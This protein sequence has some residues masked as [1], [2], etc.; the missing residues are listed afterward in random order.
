MGTIKVLEN[1]LHLINVEKRDLY[2]QD[3]QK[4]E[5]LEGKIVK[6]LEIENIIQNS[7]LV[8]VYC[9]RAGCPYCD[10]FKPKLLKVVQD[11][12]ITVHELEKGECPE[13]CEDHDVGLVPLLIKYHNGKCVKE[14]Q[15]S[16]ES[17]EKIFHFLN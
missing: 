2:S 3:M 1:D 6:T 9:Y 8:Y 7:E 10:I 14:L 15:N 16:G 5:N 13:F 4:L 17:V 11:L 12:G